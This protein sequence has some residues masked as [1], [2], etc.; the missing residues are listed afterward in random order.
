MKNKITIFSVILLSTLFF[1]IS[2]NKE[3]IPNDNNTNS[4]IK[5][6]KLIT[7]TSG[8]KT[9]ITMLEFSDTNAYD[10]ILSDLYQQVETH[11]DAFI[12]QYDSL[13]DSL[14]NAKEEE[15]GYNDQQPLIDFENSLG[16]TNSMRQVYDVDVEDWL[17]HDTLDSITD[18]DNTY[19]F[20]IEEMAM[21]NTGGEVKIG[22]AILKLTNEGFIEFTDGDVNK[23]ARFNSG[24]MTVLNE[25]NVITSLTENSRSSN[26]KWWKGKNIWD[27]YAS[28]RKVKKHLHF[29]AYPW[30]GTS[31]VRITSY[32]KRGRRWKRY[33]MYMGVQNTS[34]FYDR[35]DC[36]NKIFQEASIW[37]R[38]K[39]KTIR[40][41]CTGWGAFPG[42][43]AK[44]WFSV[45]GQF[46][47]SGKYN[48]E[49][50]SW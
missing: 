41:H 28:K 16:F 44:N 6:V 3:I 43:R 49:V 9:S 17:N 30:K 18:P 26:C 27:K 47:Y 4:N 12:A 22:T 11:E 32:K 25:P 35:N 29:H 42:Y 10:S 1:I 7:L 38:K 34:E 2:C 45:V 19:V 48:Y 20:D 40:K 37:R 5:V 15:I 31:S 21:L 33:R 50:L 8:Y 13:N 39:K 24:D 14:L 23:L 46:E 36:D